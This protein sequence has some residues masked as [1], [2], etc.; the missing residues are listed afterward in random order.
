MAHLPCGICITATV[1]P[2]MISDTK[3]L[4]LYELSHENIGNVL[5]KI[6]FGSACPILSTYDLIAEK[7]EKNQFTGFLIWILAF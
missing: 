4:L 2:D 3:S 6:C 1:H 5:K 7:K